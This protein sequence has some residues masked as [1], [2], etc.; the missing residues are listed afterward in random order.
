MLISSVSTTTTT[1]TCSSS[2]CVLAST[3]PFNARPSSLIRAG[4]TATKLVGVS[5]PTPTTPEVLERRWW[6]RLPRLLSAPAEVF[7][8]LR[9]ES[10]EAGDARQEPLV[11]V[12]LL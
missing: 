9:D 11:A 4:T 6:S 7:A 10:R 12:A 2:F 8:E 3:V 5:A 1:T